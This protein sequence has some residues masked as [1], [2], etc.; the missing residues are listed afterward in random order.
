MHC[1][2]RR[3]R[4]KRRILSPDLGAAHMLTFESR[5]AAGRTL[6]RK[7]KRGA[8]SAFRRS[9]QAPDLLSILL[10]SNAGRVPR[11]LPI[12]MGRMAVSPF[13]FYRGSAA[14]M[15]SDL[16]VLP[17]SGLSVQICGDAHV[18]NLGAY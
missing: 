12:K 10:A 17:V 1:E 2:D 4:S 15:A 9:A 16:S 11:L 6:R 14:L 7:L 8:H 13:A 3:L 5:Y 18:R